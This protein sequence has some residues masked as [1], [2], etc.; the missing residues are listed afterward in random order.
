M[1]QEG[2][3]RAFRGGGGGGGCSPRWANSPCSSSSSETKRSR[4]WIPA[5]LWCAWSQGD[6]SRRFGPS[7]KKPY[8]VERVREGWRMS[9]TVYRL[10][11]KASQTSDARLLAFAGGQGR[12]A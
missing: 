3:L 5:T 1:A 10:M 12:T 6:A 4:D 9:A 7:E 11:K 8:G 2:G